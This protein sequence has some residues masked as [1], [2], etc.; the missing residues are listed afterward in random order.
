MGKLN[1]DVSKFLE[2]LG[3][4]RAAEIADLRQCLLSA[5]SDLI[6]RI[7]WNAPSYGLGSEDRITMRLQPK[8]TL[9]LIFHRGAAPKDAAEFVFHDP[10]KLLSW[11]TADRGV[12]DI[13]DQEYLQNH[14][15]KI[16]VL[17]A[18]WIDATT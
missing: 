4:P 9:Q 3:H 1:Y 5:H 17:A 2:E 12:L 8:D 10:A 15:S 13:P 18:H 14:V 6:E 16:A 11:R 7:K